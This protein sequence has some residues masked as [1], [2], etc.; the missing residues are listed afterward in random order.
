LSHDKEVVSGVYTKKLIYNKGSA[1][2]KVIETPIL[3]GMTK[4]NTVEPIPLWIIKDKKV[5]RL[6]PICVAGLG[7]VLIHRD[8]LEKVEFGLEEDNDDCDDFCFFRKLRDNKIVPYCDTSVICKH[9][10]R[11]WSEDVFKS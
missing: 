8:I 10:E 9:L 1:D 11:A 4:E 5:K 6:I 7:C 2:E 3:F